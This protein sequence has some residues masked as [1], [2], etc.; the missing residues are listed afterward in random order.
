MPTALVAT[1]A[2]SNNQAFHM[3]SDMSAKSAELCESDTIVDVFYGDDVHFAAGW[4]G[5]CGFC[6]YIVVVRSDG[7]D[8]WPDVH[9]VGGWRK[10]K[11]VVSSKQWSGD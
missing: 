5:R 10:R 7:E 11:P 2:K 3:G 8:E 9:P 1:H 4:W 6:G